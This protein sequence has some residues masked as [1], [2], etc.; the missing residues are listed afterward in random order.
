MLIEKRETNMF[1]IL[2]LIKDAEHHVIQDF[3]LPDSVPDGTMHTPRQPDSPG[4]NTEGENSDREGDSDDSGGSILTP[5]PT[6]TPE[7]P[8]TRRTRQASPLPPPS[9]RRTRMQAG[10]IDR[11][12]YK[13]LNSKETANIVNNVSHA[14]PVPE[15]HIHMVR[16]LHA[17]QDEESFD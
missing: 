12:D 5:T 10:E 11:P 15:S 4:S 9:D 17:L 2:D 8:P 13:K 1:L 7:P 6:Q 14:K 16:V 3:D